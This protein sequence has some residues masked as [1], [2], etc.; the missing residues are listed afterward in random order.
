MVK[1][2]HGLEDWRR[3]GLVGGKCEARIEKVEGGVPSVGSSTDH[4]KAVYGP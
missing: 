1:G 4:T 2:Y 3:Q